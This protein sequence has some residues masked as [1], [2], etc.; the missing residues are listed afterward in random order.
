MLASFFLTFLLLH[1]WNRKASDWYSTGIIL[2]ILVWKLSV[3]IVDF[4]TVIK[5]PLTLIYFHGGTVGYWSGLLAAGGYLLLK[6][7]DQISVTI[8]VWL[9]TVLFFELVFHLLE[10]E[11]L[12]GSIQFVFNGALL[13]Y[14]KGKVRGAKGNVW[15][16]QLLIVFTLLQILFHSI[17]GAFELTTA[18]WT[19]LVAAAYFTFLLFVRR[20]QSE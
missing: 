10:K 15:S 13:L 1:F 16:G 14:V 5:H 4:Q 3:I 18:D 9:I 7:V 2:F 17:N 12:I 8:L 20:K 6:R 19:Y 11:Y